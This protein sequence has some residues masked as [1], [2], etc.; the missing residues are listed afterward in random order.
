MSRRAFSTVLAAFNQSD[1]AAGST[2]ARLF[3]SGEGCLRL[4]LVE[5]GGELRDVLARIEFDQE[6]LLAQQ[7]DEQ[8]PRQVF[9]DAGQS[10]RWTND[11]GAV[12]LRAVDFAIF[13]ALVVSL[14]IVTNASQRCIA[15]SSPARALS[16]LMAASLV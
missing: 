12:K 7:I 2:T 11:S 5:A 13:S 14:T 4:Q 9:H 8:P 10:Q 16:F 15:A 6:L 3:Q 1:A